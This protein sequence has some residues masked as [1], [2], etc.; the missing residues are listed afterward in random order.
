MPRLAK[1]EAMDLT[2]QRYGRLTVISR[3]ENIGS[4]TRWNCRCDCGSMTVVATTNLRSG[5]TT[6][7]RQCANRSRAAAQRTDL[8]GQRFGRLTV[9][10]AA[11]AGDDGAV[12]VCRCDCGHEVTARADHLKSGAIKSCGCLNA[13]ISAAKADR[14]N[15]ENAM[16]RIDGTCVSKIESTTIYRNNVSGVRGVYWSESQGYWI[17]KIGFKG[18]KYYLGSSTDFDTAVSYRKEAEEHLYGEFLDWY[19]REVAPRN[20]RKKLKSKKHVRDLTGRR[21]G[22]LTA[23]RLTG[24]VSPGNGSAFWHC[25]CD[26][27]N[28]KIAS[29][30]EL[31]TGMVQSCGCLFAETHNSDP[32][33]PK[34]KGEYG[35]GIQQRKN[36]EWTASIVV[37]RKTY[38]LG[39]SMN[40]DELIPLRQEA[41]AHRNDPDFE[42][43][44]HQ[45]RETHKKPKGRKK[46]TP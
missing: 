31:T 20:Q 34:H 22:R 17:A 28:T 2:G 37:N 24:Y 5:S 44:H 16:R 41:E 3:A 27:G 9:I 15:A 10:S 45:F 42:E 38:Y 46:E 21:F 4:R 14:M 23:I 19:Y 32:P 13:E 6:Q 11:E 35:P 26:C 12:W 29:A 39:T 7:C 40:P 8:T 1:G 36:G 43:W 33:K 30:N 25:K 18:K